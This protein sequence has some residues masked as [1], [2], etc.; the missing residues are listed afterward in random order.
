MDG[1]PGL[2]VIRQKG[3]EKGQGVVIFLYLKMVDCLVLVTVKIR[4]HVKV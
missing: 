1:G 4:N 2:V 3:S